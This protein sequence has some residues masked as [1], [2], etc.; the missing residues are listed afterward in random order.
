M[1]T[2]PTIDGLKALRLDAM[3][4]ALAEQRD[5]PGYAGLGFEER[6]GLLVDR[7]LTDRSN[8][9][10]KRRLRPPGCAPPRPSRTSTSTT[11]AAWTAPRSSPSPRH[12]GWPATRPSWSPAR[13]ARARPTWPAPWPTPRSP[14]PHRPL[15]ARP[16]HAG[17]PGHRP[18]RRAAI[19]AAGRLGPHR[20]PD[21]G[22]SA[23]SPLTS[24]QAADLLEV[25]EDRA[26]LR[27]T[28]ITSQLPVAL[29]HQAIADPTIADAI[30][31]R[32]LEKA[33]RI[34]LSGQSM[35]R[36]AA[37]PPAAEPASPA[38]QAPEPGRP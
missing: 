12:T 15:P 34:E 13:P 35:R 23:A 11:R 25:I 30:L 31:D 26:R 17:R 16:A 8:R 29:W 37:A 24:E 6:L 19:P 14:R 20:R 18:R 4:A 33:N 32:T 38:A 10:R 9:R 3:A 27:A 5:Q 2:A 1:L 28:I 36:P 21:P 22:P 7:E